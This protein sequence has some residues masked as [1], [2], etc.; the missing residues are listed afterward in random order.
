MQ[1]LTAA[2]LLLASA[3]MAQVTTSG[4]SGK[5]TSA[6]GEV[7]GATVTAK[8]EPSGTVY[9]AITNTDGRYTIQGM[10]VG[11][12]YTVEITYVG[13]QPKSFNNVT[14]LLGETRNL[15]CLWLRENRGWMPARR[16]RP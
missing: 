1:V 3:V 8:H 15:S 16:G 7:I 4:I 14:L 9:R 2:M 6:G 13:H 5:I 11:G 10:R 12:P